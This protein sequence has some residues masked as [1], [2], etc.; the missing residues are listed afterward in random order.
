LFSTED[1]ILV[2]A[3]YVLNQRVLGYPR[4]FWNVPLINQPGY[5]LLVFWLW[6]FSCVDENIWFWCSWNSPWWWSYEHSWL[7][8]TTIAQARCFA[9]RWQYSS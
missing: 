4:A 9:V 2:Y 3:T 8:S 6:S 5:I 1:T 7:S